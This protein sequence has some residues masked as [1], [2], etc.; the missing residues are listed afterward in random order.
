MT[1]DPVQALRA[2]TR[3]A[4]PLAKAAPRLLVAGATGALGAEVVRL[5]AGGATA[6]ATVVLAREPMT[7]GL[8]GVVP[9][10]V[11]DEDPAGW[12]LQPVDIGLVLFDPPR[13]F[14]GRERALWVPQPAQLPEVA[15]WLHRC[16]AHTLA[17]VAPHDQGRLPEAL[18]RGLASLDEHAVAALGF[19]R[20]LILRSARK[21][22]SVGST[23]LARLAQ[24]MLGVL[25]FMVP[26]SEQPVRAVSVARMLASALREAPAGIHIASPQTVWQ[27]SQQGGEA[28]VREWLHGRVGPVPARSTAQSG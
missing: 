23:G 5:L 3:P 18:K 24:A 21:P 17:V 13:L 28:V 14:H 10:Q 22:A 9:W 25:R 12:P 15:A 8:R 11:P 4:A 1:V 7:A 26:Q 27:A 20:V 19:K 6:H 16:G 2:A